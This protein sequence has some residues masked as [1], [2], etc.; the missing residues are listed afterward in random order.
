MATITLDKK[1]GSVPIY[2]DGFLAKR[3][4]RVF[5][6]EEYERVPKSQPARD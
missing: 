5:S 1:L 4:E 2:W 6:Q 3:F